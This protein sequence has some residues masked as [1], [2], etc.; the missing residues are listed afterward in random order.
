MGRK[1]KTQI[2]NIGFFFLFIEGYEIKLPLTG[3][4]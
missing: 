4:E 1:K 2:S 3:V